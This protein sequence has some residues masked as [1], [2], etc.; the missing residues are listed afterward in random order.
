[1]TFFDGFEYGYSRGEDTIMCAKRVTVKTVM[2]CG[3]RVG[4]VSLLQEDVPVNLCGECRDVLFG[5]ATH[6]PADR[7][8]ARVEY[9]TCPACDEQAPVF[10][11]LIQAHGDG[12][13]GLGVAP[14]AV[15]PIMR[16]LRDERKRRGLS[17]RGLADLAGSRRNQVSEWE[18][19]KVAPT[20]DSVR[21]LAAALG[22]R[23]FVELPEAKS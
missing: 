13:V 2:L 9:G 5:P 4:S 18:T 15:D 6:L 3:R 14:A 16:V 11:D 21:R 22:A 19:G 20:L 8:S 23:L 7:P 10:G 1:V 12:C 17:Q